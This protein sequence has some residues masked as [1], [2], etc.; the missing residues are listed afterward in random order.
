M[1]TLKSNQVAE[2]AAEIF[3]RVYMSHHDF[4]RAFAALLLSRNE[5]IQLDRLN[6]WNGVD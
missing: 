5:L 2:P 6:A 3:E 1:K 4:D